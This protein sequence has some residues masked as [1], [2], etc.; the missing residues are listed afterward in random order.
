MTIY[1]CYSIELGFTET[2]NYSAINNLTLH[3]ES[4]PAYIEYINNIKYTEGYFKEG[5]LHRLGGPAVIQYTKDGG[6]SSV[7]YYINGRFYSK[8]KYE[9]TLLQLKLSLL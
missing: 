2:S 5:I 4:G 8:T 7:E 3:N 9:N 6:I 1:K